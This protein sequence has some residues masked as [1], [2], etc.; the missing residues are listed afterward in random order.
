MDASQLLQQL[1]QSRSSTIFDLLRVDYRNAYRQLLDTLIK[2]RGGNDD[3]FK[4]GCR[5]I[6]GFGNR[7]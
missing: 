2:A 6:V 1:R 4:R 7:Q 3:L 5:W